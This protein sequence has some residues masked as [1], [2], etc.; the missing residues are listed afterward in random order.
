V[1]A[2]CPANRYPVEHTDRLRRT[3]RA[4]TG[5]DLIDDQGQPFGQAATFRTWRYLT[6]A[7]MEPQR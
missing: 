2:P 6:D 3:F 7:E 5:R 1:L 4:L